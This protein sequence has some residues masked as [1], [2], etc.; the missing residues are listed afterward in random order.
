[1]EEPAEILLLGPPV[2][3]V[4]TIA[5]AARRD[6]AGPVLGW[7]ARTPPRATA[8]STG[9]W[10]AVTNLGVYG[11]DLRRSASIPR[12]NGAASLAAFPASPAE[13]I[14]VC[15]ITPHGRVEFGC[16]LVGNVTSFGRSC[17]P[18]RPGESCPGKR[19][20]HDDEYRNYRNFGLKTAVLVSADTGSHLVPCLTSSPTRFSK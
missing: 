5:T 3:H 20:S 16:W 7:P 13:A 6:T 14:L 12:R 4:A 18:G 2:R 17:S 8:G 19:T 10:L 11:W 1:M 9:N 15:G